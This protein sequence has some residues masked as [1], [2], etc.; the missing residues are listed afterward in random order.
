M[1]RNKLIPI[2]VVTLLFSLMACNTPSHQHTYSES[3]NHDEIYHWHDA[4]CGHEVVG[5]K[6]QHIFKDVVTP[7]TYEKDGYTT[8]KCVICGYSYI[9]GNMGTSADGW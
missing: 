2:F 3:W 5:D 6:D 4:T 9:P 7:A 1:K 8:H